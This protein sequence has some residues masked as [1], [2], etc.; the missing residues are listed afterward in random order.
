M[1]ATAIDTIGNSTGPNISSGLRN[2]VA[3]PATKPKISSIKIDGR[4][5]R[6]ASHSAAIPSVM[7]L[8]S[9]MRS[10]SV[11]CD[12]LRIRSGAQAYRRGEWAVKVAELCRS[13]SAAKAGHLPGWQGV[14]LGDSR[15]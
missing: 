10:C 11:T 14:S 9:A 13:C 3:G 6:Q 12:R 2:P 15:F 8:A 4:W 5:M 7:M 1:I